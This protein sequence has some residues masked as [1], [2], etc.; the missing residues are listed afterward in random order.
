MIN[1]L[2]MVPYDWAQPRQRAFQLGKEGISQIM[3]NQQVAAAQNGAFVWH[4]P[5]PRPRTAAQGMAVQQRLL[6]QGATQFV[7]NLKHVHP[8]HDRQRIGLAAGHLAGLGMF[9]VC[10]GAMLRKWPSCEC[11]REHRFAIC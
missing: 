6:H 11:E 1:A 4:S 2:T 3:R 10:E 9:Q 8:Q 7:Q 5:Q